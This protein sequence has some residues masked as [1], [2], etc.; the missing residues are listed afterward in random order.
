MKWLEA[1]TRLTAS[2]E[3]YVLV[4]VLGVR[5]S[6]PRD[7]QAKMVVTR[8]HGFDTIGGGNLEHR[9]T[10]HA[11]RLLEA[12]AAGNEQ[13]AYTL[14]KDM[15]QCC[16][17]KVELLYECF[18]ATGFHVALFGAGHVG[19]ALVRILVELPCRIA[20]HDSRIELLERAHAELGEPVSVRTVVS[21]NPHS[22]VDAL[23]TGA[24]CVVMTHSHDTDFELVEAI[25]SRPDLPFC[26]LIGS[27]SKAASFRGRLARKGFSEA[28]ISRLVCPVGLDLGGGKSPMEVAVSVA[29]QLL[30]EQSGDIAGQSRLSVVS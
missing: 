15:S 28:E 16:G 8:E 23:P 1:A 29:A 24:W 22:A 13:H 9:A 26:G 6:A 12:G 3:G 11:R 19:A 5:G 21:E 2:G 17:G 20:W 30:K 18:P 27:D 7:A 10:G 14:G 25:L 4:T